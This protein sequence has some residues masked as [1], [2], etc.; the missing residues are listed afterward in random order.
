MQWF[1]HSERGYERLAR[2][3]HWELRQVQSGGL[4]QIGNRFFDG[5]PL[6]R[7]PGFRIERDEPA[8]FCGCEHGGELHTK[9]PK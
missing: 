4:R 2:S 3:R 5:F 1:G 8:F 6:T 9:V 7:R